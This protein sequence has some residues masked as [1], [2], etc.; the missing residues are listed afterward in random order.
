V[1]AAIAFAAVGACVGLI[2]WRVAYPPFRRRMSDG[3]EAFD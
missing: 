1:E 3:A 2:I